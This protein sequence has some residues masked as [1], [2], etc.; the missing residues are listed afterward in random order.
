MYDAGFEDTN[1]PFES[2]PTIPIADAD[3]P[4]HRDR[5]RGLIAVKDCQIRRS[6][7][8]RRWFCQNGASINLY[9]SDLISLWKSLDHGRA[10]GRST[11]FHHDANFHCTGSLESLIARIDWLSS[12]LHEHYT[13]GCRYL[14]GEPLETILCCQFIRPRDFYLDGISLPSITPSLHDDANTNRGLEAGLEDYCRAV[15]HRVIMVDKK[16]VGSQD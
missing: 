3:T 5:C 13:P 9:K 7:C 1:E 16:P 12:H 4:Y 6:I 10:P 11:S 14:D 8:T 2:H 15:V